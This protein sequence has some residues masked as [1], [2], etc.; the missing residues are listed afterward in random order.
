M[1]YL[2]TS[3][4]WMTRQNAENKTRNNRKRKVIDAILEIEKKKK[5]MENDTNV[6]NKSA[7]EY[8]DKTEN[9]RKLTLI[10]RSNSMIRTHKQL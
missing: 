8:A 9:T 5:G 3:S 2:N 4:T 1:L 6:L 7:E 10:A